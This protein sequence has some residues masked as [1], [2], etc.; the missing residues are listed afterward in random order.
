MADHISWTKLYTKRVEI[1]AKT[2]LLWSMESIIRSV[3]CNSLKITWKWQLLQTDNCAHSSNTKSQTSE[4]KAICS[5]EANVCWLK[6]DNVPRE[7]WEIF[8]QSARGSLSPPRP[9]PQQNSCSHKATSDRQSSP[10][11][12]TQKQIKADSSEVKEQR[13]RLVL[14]VFDLSQLFLHCQV[15]VLLSAGSS[16][17]VSHALKCQKWKPQLKKEL[18]T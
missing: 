8:C 14:T 12:R 17:S 5:Q 11:G 2:V 7:P 4:P 9:Q 18:L 10:K 1:R 3:Y 15:H 16:L 6:T 13:Q